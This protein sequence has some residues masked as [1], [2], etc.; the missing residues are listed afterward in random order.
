MNIRKLMIVIAAA[1]IVLTGCAESIVPQGGESTAQESSSE[2]TTLIDEEEQEN[3][4]DC[5]YPNARFEQQVE[6]KNGCKVKIFL[7]NDG[8][9][10]CYFADQYG[11]SFVAYC[12]Y[13]RLCEPEYNDEKKCLIVS[14][15]EVG[16]GEVVHDSP[17]SG[18]T[19][20]SLI[21]A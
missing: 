19:K 8:K 16:D 15:I 13:Y 14:G 9:F 3:F 1:S 7:F 21:Q 4:V 18:F 2:T 5:P 20:T 12:E 17:T 6:C 11:H 10:G